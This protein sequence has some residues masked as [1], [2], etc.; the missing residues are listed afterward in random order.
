MVTRSSPQRNRDRILKAWLIK[1][2]RATEAECHATRQRAQDQLAAV[3]A[4]GEAASFLSGDFEAFAREV[5]EQAA[6]A[7]GCE[8]VNVWLF[9]DTLTELR[10]VDAYQA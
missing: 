6:R 10:C 5:T 7:C 9:N 2:L 1:R 4:L 3:A 8:R